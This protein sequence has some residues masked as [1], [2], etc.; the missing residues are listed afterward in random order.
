MMRICVTWDLLLV[1]LNPPQDFTS[2]RAGARPGHPISGCEQSQQRS[3]LLD[4]LV[5]EQLYR[6]R[7]LD[8]ECPSRLQV[9]DELELGRLQD[10][11]IGGFCA[12]EDLA[13]VDADLAK[14]VQNGGA[15]AHQP[16]DFDKLARVIGRWNGITRRERRKLDT[17]A[18][19]EYVGGDEEGVG[20]VAH[21]GGE[22]GLDL[23]AGAGVEDLNL[24]SD[25]TRSFRYL[26]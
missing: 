12:L 7:H 18:D 1:L 3:A 9:D 16:A 23:T 8:A 5:G 10:R 11:Q 15:V 26:S 14:I 17:P 24:Q 13:G 4:H 6:V 25:G 2:C 22:G 20:P 19:E 21:D